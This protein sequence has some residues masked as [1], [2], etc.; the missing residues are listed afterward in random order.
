MIDAL[1]ATQK[2][3]NGKQVLLTLCGIRETCGF[4][5]PLGQPQLAYT[6]STSRRPELGTEL[7]INDQAYM[8]AQVRQSD[9]M[10][11]MVILDLKELP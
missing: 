9:F 10:H 2:I 1:D 7:T 11:R 5:S 8:V 6:P 4:S 3:D